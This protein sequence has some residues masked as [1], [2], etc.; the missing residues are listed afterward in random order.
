MISFTT[1]LI[2]HDLLC[3]YLE[4]RILMDGSTTL[5]IWLILVRLVNPLRSYKI[6]NQICMN[7]R[8][9]FLKNLHN[10]N[11]DKNNLNK[12]CCDS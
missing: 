2:N 7:L 9:N 5:N 11:Y 12:S 8:R 1:I 3:K 6:F 10:Q 4:G